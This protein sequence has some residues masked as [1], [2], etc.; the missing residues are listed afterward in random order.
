VTTIINETAGQHDQQQRADAG[1]R[2][3]AADSPVTLDSPGDDY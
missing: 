3:G 1:R 2:A